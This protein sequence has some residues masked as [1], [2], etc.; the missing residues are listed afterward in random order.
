M[1]GAACAVCLPGDPC[2]PPSRCRARRWGIRRRADGAR[3]VDATHSGRRDGGGR[4]PRAREPAGRSVRAPA[5]PRLPPRGA[6]GFEVPGRRAS[7]SSA[8]AARRARRRAARARSSSRGSGAT[9]RRGARRRA[10]AERGRRAG[11]RRLGPGGAPPHR[12]PRLRARA[13]PRA[14]GRLRRAAR[15]R[16]LRCGALGRRSGALPRR[17]LGVGARGRGT[18][19]S[20]RA[21]SARDRRSPGQE[22]E[23]L[24]TRSRGD[25][26]ARRGARPCRRGRAC[27]DR[28]RRRAG[29]DAGGDARRSE[30]S[31]RR[32]RSRRS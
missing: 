9:R 11:V 21:V 22:C 28:G 24:R 23:L 17:R 13:L 31:T 5:L 14:P 19:R 7:D 3:G 8:L 26:S 16:A 2:P 32:T 4:T 18:S 20:A 1:A 29:G 15:D 10:F 12:R 25:G 6:G 27:A 30:A